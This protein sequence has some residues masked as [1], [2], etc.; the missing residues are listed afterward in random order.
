MNNCFFLWFPLL[1][2]SQGATGSGDS[3]STAIDFVVAKVKQQPQ[4]RWISV[5]SADVVYGP[6]VVANIFAQRNIHSKDQLPDIILA[7]IDSKYM[8][9]KGNYEAIYNFALLY[10]KW[11]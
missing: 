10:S 8:L 11:M 6:E 5:T 2:F 4:C 7:P 3:T 1:Y 9:E